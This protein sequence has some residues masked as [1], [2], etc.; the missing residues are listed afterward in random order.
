MF[1]KRKK[2]NVATLCGY[3]LNPYYSSVI[4]MG[5]LQNSVKPDQTPHNAASDP[6]L[7]CLLTDCST[8]LN[9][10]ILLNYP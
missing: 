5:H 1:Y 8:D 9:K 10:K 6:G 3:Y 7:H 2:P 4:F